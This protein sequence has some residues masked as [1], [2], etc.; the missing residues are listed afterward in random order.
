MTGQIIRLPEAE[1][2]ETRLLLP[3]YAADRLDAA[4]RSRVESHLEGCAL[5]RA[6]LKQELRLKA[7]VAD[8]P[9][10][11]DH[12]WAETLARLDEASPRRPGV[13]ARITR[14]LGEAWRGG[15]AWLGWGVA[16][17]AVAALWV[18]V[19]VPRPAPPALYHALAAP[20][21]SRPGDIVVMFRPDATETQL[22]EALTASGARLVDGPTPADAYVLSAPLPARDRALAVLRA[23]HAVLAAEPI[24]QGAAP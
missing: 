13:A 7:E 24:D 11:V 15:G 22:R 16:A 5:C 20:P 21:L 1:H 18:S 9:L 6:E 19:Y 23:R 14:R 10:D 3:W 4:D 17:T 8:L 2:H 12:G